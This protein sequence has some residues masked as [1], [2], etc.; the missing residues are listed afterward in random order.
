MADLRKTFELILY[1][2]IL[3]FPGACK[4][5][6]PQQAGQSPV[7]KIAETSA[8]IDPAEVAFGYTDST[9]SKLLMLTN[10][11]QV[12]ETAKAK[13][14]VTAVCSEGIE[15]PLRYL[16]FQKRTPV[17]NGRQS[18]GNFKNDEGHL[19][20]ITGGQAEEGDTCLLVPSNYLQDFPIARNDFAKE[21]TLAKEN[22]DRIQ[23]E[24]GR[25][26]KLY[27]LLHSAGASQ[28]V[29]AVEFDPVGDSLLGSVVVVEPDRLSFF[30]QPAN[31]KEGREKGGCWRVDDDCRFNYMEMN[32]PAVLGFPGERLVFF[33]SGGPEGQIIILFQAKGGKLVELQRAY[34]YHSPL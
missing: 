29:A 31:V 23:K 34:R 18:A 28:Q 14:M 4:Q 11:N 32:V 27:W 16:E 22:V 26:I 15:F 10:D 6:A 33:T 7:E 25:T 19:Y 3:S 13:A 17:D 21:G 1:V 24:R 12:L 20:E 30:D 2:A 8:P 5:Q 9:G